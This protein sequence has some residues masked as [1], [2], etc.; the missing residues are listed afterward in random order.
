MEMKGDLWESDRKCKL[1]IILFCK[2]WCR[3]CK[4]MQWIERKRKRVS[5]EKEHQ[6]KKKRKKKEKKKSNIEIKI[7]SWCKDMFVM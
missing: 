7:C 5:M 4:E 6:R 1:T 3:Q 2:K